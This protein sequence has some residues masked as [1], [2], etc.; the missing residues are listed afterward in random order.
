MELEPGL[1]RRPAPGRRAPIAVLAILVVTM[2]VV[3]CG[4]GPQT[5]AP[6]PTATAL[7]P[8]TPAPAID[9]PIPDEDT[10]TT[11]VLLRSADGAY[12]VYASIGQLQGASSTCTA[13]LLDTG[14]S[15]TQPAYAITNGHCV[16]IFGA[17][18][19][20]IDRAAEGISVAFDWFIDRP[21]H[22]VVPVTTVAWA[23]MRNTD[24]A[25]L[26]LAATPD[27]LRGVGIRGWPLQ[28]IRGGTGASLDVVMLGVPVGAPI[29]DIPEA[30]RYLR[31]GTCSLDVDP[32]ILNERHWLWPEARRND[33]PEVLPGNSGSAILDRASGGL[34][35][36]INTTTY[37]GEKGAECW[38]GRPCEANED[39]EASLPDTSYAQPVGALATCFGDDGVFALGDACPLD[40]GG[41][42]TSLDGAPI[43]VNPASTDPLTGAP[44]P[45]SWRTTVITPS[46][47]TYRYKIG[48]L[49]TTACADEAGYSAPIATSI[50]IDDDLP[51]TEQRLLLCAVAEGSP[52]GNAAIAVA[53]IDTTPPAADVTFA[54]TGS[55][56]EGWR[57]EPVFNPPE[58]SV[59]MIKLGPAKS[60]SC[61]DSKGYEAY[62]RFPLDVAGD[63][64]PARFCAIGFDDAGNASAPAFRV[65][66]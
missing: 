23:S 10:A 26:A 14:E 33:C 38:L 11:Q 25:V 7:P 35:G 19:L 13:V 58:L 28:A 64:A 44:S 29:V 17:N 30:E 24:L 41:G 55:K 66:R 53:Y 8:S 62:R 39:G 9:L 65:L 40:A 15:A 21:E 16:G 27:E 2:I 50:P 49:A 4:D 46:P 57:I 48:P 37:K 36:L 22:R 59:F 51:L 32:V 5:P 43:A 1:P 12:D 34:V 47:T 18:E 63:K 42:V 56:A 54:V 61:A 60:T 52:L 20:V 31:L 6:P 45:V 3:A